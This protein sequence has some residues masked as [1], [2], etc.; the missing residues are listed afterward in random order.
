MPGKLTEGMDEETKPKGGIPQD[1]K[2]NDQPQDPNEGEGAS[3]ET[4]AKPAENVNV[5]FDYQSE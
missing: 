4:G 1:P 5:Q 3:E 2:P